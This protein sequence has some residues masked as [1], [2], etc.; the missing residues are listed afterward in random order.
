MSLAFYALHT[1]YRGAFVRY[2][3]VLDAGP[4]MV[5][6]VIV[7]EDGGE[8]RVVRRQ[9]VY[10]TLNPAELCVFCAVLKAPT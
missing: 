7:L 2:V 5:G 4:P 3:Q 8:Y 9:H 10:S 1:E 6:D